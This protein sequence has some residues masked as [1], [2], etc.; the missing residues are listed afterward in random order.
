MSLFAIASAITILASVPVS[1]QTIS[2]GAYYANP[3]WDQQLP[4][5]QRFIVLSNWNNEA[6]LD[7]ETGLVWQRT[8]AVPT[9]TQQFPLAVFTCYGAITGGRKGWRLPAPEELLS[10]TDPTQTNP[11]LPTGHP[12]ENINS[13][14]FYWTAST[15]FPPT[16]GQ[17]PPRGTGLTVGIGGGVVATT[18]TDNFNSGVWCVRGGSHLMSDFATQN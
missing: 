11:S 15:L 10:L 16:P 4:A 2:N 3:S 1:A 6:V 7:R 8:P 14:A 18:G 17:T 12:F 9:N 13:G 5:A